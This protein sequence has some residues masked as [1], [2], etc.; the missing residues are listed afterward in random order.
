MAELNLA[1]QAVGLMRT[2]MSEQMEKTMEGCKSMKA[3]REAAVTHP[4]LKEALKDSLEPVILLLCSLFQRLK[5]KG[6]PFSVFT[7]ATSSEMDT[8]ASFVTQIDPGINPASCTKSDLA[9]F[10]GLK[11][12]L[13]H[14]CQTRHYSF[15]ILKCGSSDC[16]I[17]KPP[18]LP[19]EVFDTLQYLLDPICDGNMYKPFSE[20]YGTVTTEKDRPSFK[21]SA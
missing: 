16:R 3:I 21:S 19:K 20:V 15:T 2:K 7:S 12:F 5:L 8:L 17:C 6:E 1:L 10:P 13:N 11:Q 9:H 14:C 18:C 4:E